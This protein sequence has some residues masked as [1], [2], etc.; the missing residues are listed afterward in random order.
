M[1]KRSRTDRKEKKYYFHDDDGKAQ[2]IS[3]SLK[4]NDFK[5]ICLGEV[6]AMPG[7][8]LLQGLKKRAIVEHITI[9]KRKKRR[10]DI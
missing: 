5:T 7:Q 6:R 1:S 9:N 8:N 10:K 3:C 4:N 2:E